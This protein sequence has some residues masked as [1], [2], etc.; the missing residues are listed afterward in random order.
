MSIR[1]TVDGDLS[2]ITRYMTRLERE[3]LPAA[4]SD[5]LARTANA[6]K[7]RLAQTMG[8]TLHVPTPYTMRAA[9]TRRIDKTSIEVGIKD[10]AMLQ[11]TGGASPADVLNHLFAGGPRRIKNFERRLQ[12][13]GLMPRD[14]IAVPGEAAPVDS[15]GNVPRQF[16][17]QML[18]YLQAFRSEQNMTDQGRERFGRRNARKVSAQSIDYFVSHGRGHRVGAGSWRRGRTQHLPAGIWQRTRFGAGTAIKPIIMFV[19][20]G[21]YRRRFDLPTI[22]RSVLAERWDR[23]LLEAVAK[24]Q[25]RP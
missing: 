23:Y 7:Q 14:T 10:R 15:H 2:A 4:T 17:V 18:A 25:G 13:V 21:R 3:I 16:L 9:I 12:A 11:K 1:F 19:R 22:A 20:V 5:A 24:H 6:I 8:S